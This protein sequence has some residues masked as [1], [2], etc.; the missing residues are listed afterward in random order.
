MIDP[1]D[2]TDWFEA[3]AAPLVLYARQWLAGAI[4]EDVVQEVFVRLMSERRPPDNVKAWLYRAVRN[5]AISQWR[6]SRRRRGREIE[7]ASDETWFEPGRDESIDA[8]FAAELIRQLPAE[9]RESVVLRI[10]GGLTLAEISA[11]TGSPLSTVFH[12]YQQ[13]LRA[14]RKQM[15]VPCEKK[16]D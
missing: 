11:I 5:E 1:A 3:H 6:S 15:G 2:V 7:V 14:V 12:H 4:A 10:W 16:N 13:G 9:Q 8:G